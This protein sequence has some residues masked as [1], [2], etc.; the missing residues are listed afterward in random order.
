[1]KFFSALLEKPNG[2]EFESQEPRE[3]LYFI[4][5]RHPIT[6]LG[7]MIT[8][9]IMAFAPLIA[10][11]IAVDMQINFFNL[12]PP[13]YQIVAIIIWYLVTMLFAFESFLIWY[14]NVYII[15]RKRLIDVDFTGFWGKRISE[16]SYDNV[17]DVS[18]STNKFWHILFNYGDIFMQTAAEQTEFEFHAVPKPGLV[19]DKLTDLVERYKNR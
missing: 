13:E 6:N 3:E 7:W 17:E 1:M 16:A 19:H 15:T 5:R 9:I 11:K 10:M 12:I 14:F 18:Y 2:I 4:L 8:S